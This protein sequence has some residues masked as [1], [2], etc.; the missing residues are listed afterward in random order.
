MITGYYKLANSVAYG[1]NPTSKKIVP[2]RVTSDGKLLISG[3]GV[4]SITPQVLDDGVNI[5][6]NIASGVNAE[7]TLDGNRTLDNPTNKVAGTRGKI[8]VIQD[9]T[10]GS[11]TLAYG[12]DYKFPGGTAPVLSLGVNDYDILD[13]YIDIALKIN[14]VTSLDFG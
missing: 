3:G 11:R 7:V 5:S 9:A 13:Y 1:Y 4:V 6:W 2:L 12:T 14:V 10:T 8:K